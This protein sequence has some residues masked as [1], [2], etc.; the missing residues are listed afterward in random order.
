MGTVGATLLPERRSPPG[1]MAPLR[2]RF[3][4]EFDPVR[5]GLAITDQGTGLVRKSTAT[6]DADGPTH[7]TP[8]FLDFKAPRMM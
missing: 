4:T 7:A 2:F 5:D 8:Y 1:S 6:L 3:E